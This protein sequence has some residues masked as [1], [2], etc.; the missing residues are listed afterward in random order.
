MT[1]PRAMDATCSPAFVAALDTVFTTMLHTHPQR[2]TQPLPAA[3]ASEASV[4]ALVGVS[5]SDD[6]MVVLRF[7]RTTAL[8]IAGHLLGAA[9]DTIDDDVADALAEVVNMVAGAAKARFQPD[10]PLELGLPTVVE[11]LDYKMRY[12][13]QSAWFEA[14]FTSDVGV[15][16]MA[17]TH[18]PQASIAQ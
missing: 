5:G 10:P 11:G 17:V 15:F 9:P 16:T 6:G 4:T 3:A 7:P 1:V 12:P 18:N 13:S 14:S 2:T 8:Q